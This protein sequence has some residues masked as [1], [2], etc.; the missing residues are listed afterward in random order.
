[1]VRHN[2]PSHMIKKVMPI[3]KALQLFM[4]L[5]TTKDIIM[6]LTVDHT[7][8]ILHRKIALLHLK[9]TIMDI[10]II[11]LLKLDMLMPAIIHRNGSTTRICSLRLDEEVAIRTNDRFFSVT[12][13]HPP[14]RLRNIINPITKMLTSSALMV[15]P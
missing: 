9:T 4:A 13:L 11:I 6:T 5:K 10:L 3:N 14:S 1:M 8:R 15:L 7:S 2:T 12:A